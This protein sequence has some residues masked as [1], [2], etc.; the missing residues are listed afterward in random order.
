MKP[1]HYQYARH[2]SR[3]ATREVGKLIH[4]CQSM[5]NE[6]NL[7]NSENIGA[8]RALTSSLKPVFEQNKHESRKIENA[9]KAHAMS[10]EALKAKTTDTA[11]SG[12]S[13]ESSTDSPAQA[14]SDDGDGDGDGDPDSEPPH[15]TR[16]PRSTPPAAASCG[17]AAVGDPL[18][19]SVVQFCERHNI[20]KPTF[21]ELVKRGTAPRIMKVGRRTLISI[22]AAAD[23]R[24][25]MEQ[26]AQ[27]SRRSA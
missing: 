23:W 20:T 13:C 27:L 17:S 24:R 21:Y 1:F 19:L 4:L 12:E 26:G 6:S 16:K 7:L 3:Q 25:Q 11:D 10:R 22:E 9:K 15:R 2:M 14:D 8:A 5:V 18:A